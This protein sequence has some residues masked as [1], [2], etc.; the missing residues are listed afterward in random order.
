MPRSGEP[1]VLDGDLE[2]L[3]GPMGLV[4]GDRQGVAGA[5]EGA[6][7]LA[8]AEGD[9]DIQALTAV[10]LDRLEERM[11]RA[12]G[13]GHGAAH[14]ALL[15]VERQLGLDVLDVNEPEPLGLTRRAGLG[16]RPPRRGRRA[17]GRAA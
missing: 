4:E 7:C 10:Q 11:Q 1:A 15:G 8:G 14:L 17:L 5:A 3:A 16:E 12:H 13:V 9:L 6:R 2:R